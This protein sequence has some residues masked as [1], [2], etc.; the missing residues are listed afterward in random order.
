[1]PTT[2]C[3]AA[4]EHRVGSGN[5][6]VLVTG[7]KMAQQLEKATRDNY[8]LETPWFGNHHNPCHN[9]ILKLAAQHC[10][11]HVRSLLRLRRAAGRPGRNRRLRAQT[12]T[13]SRMPIFRLVNS[14]GNQLSRNTTNSGIDR[15]DGQRAFLRRA[16][17]EVRNK[18][19]VLRPDGT[20]HRCSL[21][22]ITS[23][24]P[25]EATV[26]QRRLRI[27]DSLPVRGLPL[28]K[29]TRKNSLQFGSDGNGTSGRAA[30]KTAG[31]RACVA[32][33][34]LAADAHW[35]LVRWLGTSAA[36][37]HRLHF[38][39]ATLQ[40]G[41]DGNGTPGRA[42]CWT[43][44]EHARVAPGKPAADD[45]WTLGGW[46]QASATTGNCIRDGDF[47]SDV[48]ERRVKDAT[49]GHVK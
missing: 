29:K 15:F 31:E 3:T 27:P 28:N 1:M 5:G 4:V 32:P 48:H 49:T 9:Q 38:G 34:T 19:A 13:R 18:E 42:A 22:S 35:T 7:V 30:C 10:L 21:G 46:L 2:I 44:G 25:R 17:R 47:T 11:S 36:N 26:T 24:A 37:G 20:R 8:R 6:A 41:T 33:G 45:R 39:A 23:F 14:W 16:V 43:A 40:S 12:E